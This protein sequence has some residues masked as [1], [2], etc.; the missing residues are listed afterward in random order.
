MLL[1]K[2]SR[3]YADRTIREVWDTIPHLFVS[4][5]DVTN[6][7]PALLVFY[8]LIIASVTVWVSLAVTML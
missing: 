5:G 2:S 1:N 7:K 6:N 8:S 4:G 3:D